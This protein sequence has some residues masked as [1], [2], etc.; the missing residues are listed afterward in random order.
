MAHGATPVSERQVTPAGVAN[1]FVVYL[2]WGS[3]YLAI[4]LAVREGDGFAPFT[5]GLTRLVAA[6]GLLFAW[7]AIRRMRLRLSRSEFVTLAL[8]GLLLW[9]GANGLVNLAEQRADSGYAALLVATVPIWT[10]A[11]EILLDRRR[12]SGRLIASLA[13][14]FTGVAALAAPRLAGAAPIDAI[15]IGALLLAPVSWAIGSVMQVR[16]P[17]GVRPLVGAAYLH[18]FGAAGFAVIAVAAHEPHPWPSSTAWGAWAYLVVAGSLI[19][20]PAFVRVLRTL[21]TNIA[22]TYAYVN[23]LVAMLLGWMVLREPVTPSM[24][25]GMTLILAGV[26]GVFRSRGRNTTP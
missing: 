3:T 7:A 4:R 18:A 19:A 16:R 22:M 10:A 13:V 1:L 24:L 17:V 12:P 21:P 6:G 8:C 14:G 5:L 9:P 26:W 20:F 25:A 11:I 23:P 2:V 15:S